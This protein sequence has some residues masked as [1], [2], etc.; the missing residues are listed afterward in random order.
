V[1]WIVHSLP[2]SA[3]T[4]KANVKSKTPLETHIWLVVL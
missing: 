4:S 2:R 1:E 3:P